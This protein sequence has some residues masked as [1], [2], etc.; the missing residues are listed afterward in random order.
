MKYKLNEILSAALTYYK[1]SREE[2][3]TLKNRRLRKIVNIKQI[4]S[5]IAFESGYTHQEI[6]QFL[7]RGRC[8]IIHLV[9]VFK[10]QCDIYSEYREAVDSIISSLDKNQPYQVSH[11]QYGWLARNATGLLTLSPVKP[12]KMAGFWI[13]EGTK[14]F[15]SQ[16]SFP[17]ITYDSGPVQVKIRTTIEGNEKM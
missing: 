11:Y 16:Q 12:E 15:S 10:E 3:E 2:W 1:F 6:G 4:V 7:G 14:P 5:L 17:Q 8:D 9:N 13:A